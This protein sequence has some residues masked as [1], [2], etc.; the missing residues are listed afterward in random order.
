MKNIDLQTFGGL[1]IAHIGNRGGLPR[2]KANEQTSLSVIL[3]ALQERTISHEETDE[4]QAVWSVVE[5]F[6]KA[7]GEQFFSE[8]AEETLDGMVEAFTNKIQQAFDDLKN[9]R[10]DVDI[11]AQKIDNAIAKA[12]ASDPF[13]ATNMNNVQPITDNIPEIPWHVVETVGDESNIVATV[14]NSIPRYAGRE[15]TS[16]E[17]MSAAY[18]QYAAQVEEGFKEISLT[19]ETIERIL[20]ELAEKYNGPADAYRRYINVFTS[21]DKGV[22]VCKSIA[23]RMSTVINPTETLVEAMS[24]LEPIKQVVE[25]L[26][27]TVLSSQTRELLDNNLVFVNR[28]LM[29]I[30]YYIIHARR[31]MYK[32]AILVP[33]GQLNTD[34]MP[35]F[36][37]QGGTI[38]KLRQHV[39]FFYPEDKLAKTAGGVTVDAVIQSESVIK[40]RIEKDT[41]DVK[42]RV[43]AEL[44]RI[45][46]LSLTR[47]FRNYMSEN[48]AQEIPM[49]VKIDKGRAS[50][51]VRIMS[52]RLS[53]TTVEDALYELIM[54]IYYPDQFVVVLYRRL[55]AEMTKELAEQTD[56]DKHQIRLIEARVL[57]AMITEFI[58]NA[59]LIT[60]C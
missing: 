23:Q 51:L 35:M 48:E 39:K 15:I 45:T 10:N 57:A 6:V 8:Q 5:D 19:S 28:L 4:E 43:Q 33:T 41:R 2:L 16:A 29:N 37:E 38:T 31:V 14:N 25:Q 22:R 30:A 42:Q 9:I 60:V 46:T 34:N 26:R 11:L 18:T 20:T 58:M 36:L 53:T 24:I 47:V 21:A 3:H 50:D 40:E 7:L 44:Q 13:L 12:I 54:K 55:G 27:V 1:L 56:V 52:E 17:I 32:N 49:V 59:E